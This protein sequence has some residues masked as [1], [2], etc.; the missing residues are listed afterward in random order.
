VPTAANKPRFIQGVG[1]Y[2][3]GMRVLAEKFNSLVADGFY[4]FQCAVQIFRQIFSYR[5]Q[6]QTDIPNLHNEN[7]L[8]IGDA[9]IISHY[10]PFLAF[11]F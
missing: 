4:L 6:L 10:L 3:R 8:S 9:S 2:F 7:P 5:I 1:Y 11:D